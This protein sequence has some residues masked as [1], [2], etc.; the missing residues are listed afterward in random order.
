MDSRAKEL[1]KQ[2]DSLFEQRSNLMAHWQNTA[3]QFYPERADFTK[4]FIPGENMADNL[5]TSIPIIMRRDLGNMF[6]SMLRPRSM[7]WFEL[8]AGDDP[9]DSPQDARLWLEEK[10]ATQKN[11]MYDH[12]SG[13]D[14]ATKGADQDYVTFG[15]API[16]VEINSRDNALLLRNRHLRDVVWCDDFTGRTYKVHERMKMSAYQLAGNFR[17]SKLHKEVRKALDKDPQKEFECRHIVMPLDA[18]ERIPGAKNFPRAKFVSIYIDVDNGHVIEEAP[19]VTLKYVIPRWQPLSNSQYSYSQAAIAALPE[20]RGLQAMTNTI[21][22]AGEN[23]VRP[24]LIA[25]E[26]ALR[27]D[28]NY[29]SG[30]VTYVSSKYDERTGDPLRPMELMK[31]GFNA[32]IELL[33]RARM[34]LREAFFLDKVNLPVMEPGVTA[35]EIAQRTQEYIRNAMPL[36]DPVESEYNAPLCEMIFEEMMAYGFFGND[37]PDSLMDST[38]RFKFRSPL[39]EA[40]DQ[41]KIRAFADSK[42]LIADT[43]QLDPDAA[44]MIDLRKA[45]RETLFASGVPADWVREEEEFESVAAGWAQKRQEAEAIAMAGQVGAVAE[46]GGKGAKAVREAMQ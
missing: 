16:K 36:F 43:M 26:E 14:R 11:A 6:S 25:V 37:I 19:S 1:I 20:A 5:A 23:Y 46:Q 35:F 10:Q 12:V 22:E 18:Y 7:Q 41:I 17:E 32:G 27:S 44:A 39:R 2:G 38:V 29:Y 15:Q 45:L 31:G 30:G 4:S 40:E 3:E 8:T 34:V 24:P 28:L 9:S 21:L 42:A 33:D 13:F